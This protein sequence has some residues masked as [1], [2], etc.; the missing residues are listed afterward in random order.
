MLQW[1]GPTGHFEFCELNIK[2]WIFFHI[3]NATSDF[4][5][6]KVICAFKA[7]IILSIIVI[8]FFGQDIFL[9]LISLEQAV[10]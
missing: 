10:G 6:V 1:N 7:Y 2:A 9:C 8:L 3:T 5:F 4:K